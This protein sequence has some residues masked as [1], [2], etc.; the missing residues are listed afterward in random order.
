MCQAS[1]Q[2]R[3]ALLFLGTSCVQGTG[4]GAFIDAFSHCL[5]QCWAEVPRS[6]FAD[7][8]TE[9]PRGL[10]SCPRS[11]CECLI[12]NKPYPERGLAFVLS[13]WE[14]LSKPLQCLARSQCLCLLGDF[15]PRREVWPWVRLSDLQRGWTL[16]SARWVIYHVYAMEPQ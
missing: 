14:V 4:L 1:G 11:F 3:T 2:A 15:G 8:K 9:V 6:C 13:P 16:R 10:V 7:V 12:R 5:P